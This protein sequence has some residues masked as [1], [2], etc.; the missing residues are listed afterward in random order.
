MSQL[1]GN[2][3]IETQRERK[4]KRSLNWLKVKRYAHICDMN[5][6]Y[7]MCAML[8]QNMSNPFFHLTIKLPVEKAPYSA[9][10]NLRA[11]LTC[12]TTSD[13]EKYNGNSIPRTV[14]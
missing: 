7:E 14:R 2:I 13:N 10:N 4:R 9:S 3:A 5:N 11:N 8:L 12:A 6:R 1:Y